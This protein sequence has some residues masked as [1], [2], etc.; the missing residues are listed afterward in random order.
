M[1]PKNLPLPDLNDMRQMLRLA[2]HLH[3]LPPMKRGPAMVEGLAS[4]VHAD[5]GAAWVGQSEPVVRWRPVGLGPGWEIDA[6]PAASLLARTQ[7][8][9][10]PVV[11][12]RDELVPA[13]LWQGSADAQVRDSVDSLYSLH[14][15]S[16]AISVLAFYRGHARDRWSERERGIVQLVHA[17]CVRCVVVDLP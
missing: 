3:D 6:D 14:R 15:E 7:R 4:L 5:R 2:C 11:R 8:K 9:R 12:F 10:T 16:G 1:S 13:A 17:Q